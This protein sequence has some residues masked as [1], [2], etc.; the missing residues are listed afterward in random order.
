M[1]AKRI[2][3]QK[4]HNLT[5]KKK[6]NKKNPAPVLAMKSRENKH[7]NTTTKANSKQMAAM[8]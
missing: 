4:A 1:L 3:L 2:F 7:P 5:S 8:E 6:N